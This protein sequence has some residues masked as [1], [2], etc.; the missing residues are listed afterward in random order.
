ML[1]FYLKLKKL[2]DDR[3]TKKIFICDQFFMK[4]HPDLQ[5]FS[6]EINQIICRNDLIF[7]VETVPP[8]LI[9]KNLENVLLYKDISMFK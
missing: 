1:R 6:S 3:L 8:K 9:C 7:D 2:P 4:N 5:C